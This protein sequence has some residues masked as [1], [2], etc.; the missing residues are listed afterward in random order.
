MI[1]FGKT[2]KA[3]TLEETTTQLAQHQPSGKAWDAKNIQGTTNRNLTK[4]LSAPANSIQV[5]IETLAREFNINTAVEL[6]P[7]WLESVG[8]PD[9]C[10]T[11][12]ES[13]EAARNAVIK[14]ISKVPV[15]N[16]QDTVDLIYSLTGI[17]ATVTPGADN[18]IF[19]MNFPITF[20]SSAARFIVSVIVNDVLQEGFI[21]S[22]PITIGSSSNQLVRCVLEQ[23][24]PANV[25]IIIK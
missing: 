13:D 8:L 5:L 9:T 1:T 23:I 19:T 18:E 6:L 25:V 2:A 3:P 11:E 24:L 4:G 20:S 7:E 12:F 17:N 10:Q 21:Y 16:V 22:F 14:R 15:V